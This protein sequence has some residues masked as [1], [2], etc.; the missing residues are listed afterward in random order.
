[1]L[2]ILKNQQVPERKFLSTLAAPATIQ[3]FNKVKRVHLDLRSQGGVTRN[4]SKKS[5][6]YYVKEVG[7]KN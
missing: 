1:M 7:M 6:E 2:A 4:H 5:N 3:F